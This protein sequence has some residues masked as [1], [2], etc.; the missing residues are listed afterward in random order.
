[1]YSLLKKNRISYIQNTDIETKISNKTEQT[2]TACS[3][4]HVLTSPSV[5]GFSCSSP[6]R[7]PHSC[8][9]L[10]R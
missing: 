1:M 9:M 8:S 3:V 2:V 6:P 10:Q 5:T 7:H 4:L